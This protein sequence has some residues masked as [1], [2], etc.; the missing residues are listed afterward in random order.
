[1]SHAQKR[2]G[3][4]LDDETYADMGKALGGRSASRAELLEQRWIRLNRERGV[5]D[6][7]AR[8]QER[9]VCAIIV[10]AV[11]GRWP[12][13]P[14][15]IFPALQSIVGPRAFEFGLKW[16]FFTNHNM[17]K[18]RY[19]THKPHA[20]QIPDNERWE[21]VWYGPDPLFEDSDKDK[22]E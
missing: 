12:Q 10:Q 22:E 3:L 5:S 13:E 7:T 4:L 6:P 1:M 8:V 2:D 15:A 16:T 9:A 20:S 21:I 18:V 11:Q 14:R 19:L 17:G